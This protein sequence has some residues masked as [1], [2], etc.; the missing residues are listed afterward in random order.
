MRIVYFDFDSFAVKDEYRPVIEAQAKRLAANR[1]QRATI[2]GTGRAV[3]DC[4]REPEC[5][6]RAC[7]DAEAIHVAGVTLDGLLSAEQY[8]AFLGTL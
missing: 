6:G 7:S 1:N 2:D 5:H 8:D 4:I 3:G